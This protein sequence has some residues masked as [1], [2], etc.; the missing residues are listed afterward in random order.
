MNKLY[1]NKE[2]TVWNYC[3]LTFQMTMSV[4]VPLGYE[5]FK[6]T[7]VKPVQMHYS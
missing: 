4:S 1:I 3:I 6:R 7:S 5:K 2:F